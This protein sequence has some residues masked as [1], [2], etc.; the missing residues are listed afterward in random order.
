MVIWKGDKFGIIHM[1]DGN[2]LKIR[3]SNYGEFFSII[4]I[5]GYYEYEK[6]EK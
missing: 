5:D 6:L 4:G 3:V 1:K 2:E